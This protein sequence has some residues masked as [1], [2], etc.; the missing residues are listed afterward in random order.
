MKGK[1]GRPGIDPQVKKIILRMAR[2]DRDT[3]RLALARQIIDEI[4]SKNRTAPTEQTVMKL[5]SEARR[6]VE[7]PLDSL[8][9]TAS[10][11]KY[12]ICA[13]ALPVIFEIKWQRLTSIQDP[14]FNKLSI[15]EARWIARLY[16]LAKDSKE[17]EAW[18]VFYAWEESLR[19]PVDT[20]D[21]PGTSKL[22][23]AIL[24]HIYN[25][26]GS[27]TW[28]SWLSNTNDLSYP[29][30]KE[31]LER[32]ITTLEK[33][34]FDLSVELPDFA[35]LPDMSVDLRVYDY[36][37]VWLK[38]LSGKWPTISSVK[39]KG[40]VFQLRNLIAKN[41]HDIPDKAR[42]IEKLVNMI[43]FQ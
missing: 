30:R 21:Q 15:R 36:Y 7:S 24:G 16:R 17:L 33:A 4:N 32:E 29:L 14:R 9:S 2:E 23:D 19:E 35:P 38:H 12:E 37:L 10:F 8:W 39:R 3:K 5:I 28:W 27:L 26:F 41:Y 20:G 6:Q 34:E 42:E 22:D 25:G 13:E 40:L 11:E 1:R 18:A 43:E 31:L